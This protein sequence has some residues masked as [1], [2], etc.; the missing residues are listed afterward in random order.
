MKLIS[1]QDLGIRLKEY[2]KQNN[3]KMPVIEK[4][5][6]VNRAT[7]YKWE[8]GTKPGNI[9]DFLAV[10]A[11]LDEMQFG[12][13]ADEASLHAERPLTKSL[14][15]NPSLSAKT[16]TDSKVAAGTVITKNN[17]LELVVDY[18]YAPSLGVIEGLIEVIGDSMEPFL[19][20]GYRVGIRR[21]L[22]GETLSWGS[23]F[24]IIDSNHHCLLRRI[25]AGDSSEDLLLVSENPQKYP[26]INWNKDQIKSIFKVVTITQKC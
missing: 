22:S 11:Y 7:M 26:S 18:I 10:K 17:E 3:I 24:F 15:L 8:Q 23:L 5:T 16:Q 2:R 13:M 21:L 12:L 6:G 14:P 4:A 9:N 1:M 19:K 25:Y 20:S